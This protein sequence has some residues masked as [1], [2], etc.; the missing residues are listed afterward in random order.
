MSIRRRQEM[1]GEERKNMSTELLVGRKE[2]V[3]LMTHATHFYLWLYG[4]GHTQTH[5]HTHTHTYMHTHIHTYIW[6]SR[7]PNG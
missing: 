7:W 2:R 3:Y 4:V 1:S 5:T 6:M